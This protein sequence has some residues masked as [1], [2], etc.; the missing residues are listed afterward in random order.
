MS[1]KVSEV[2]TT[3]P[4]TAIS[5]LIAFGVPLDQFVVVLT[6]VYLILQIAWF[7][8]SKYKVVTDGG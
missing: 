7:I 8:Y 4:P 2:A 5:G 6:L 1:L 3:A